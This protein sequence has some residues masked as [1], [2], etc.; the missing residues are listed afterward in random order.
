MTDQP[1][2]ADIR[3]RLLAKVLLT[4]QP[5]VI[6]EIQEID[7]LD[8]LVQ[9]VPE[10]DAEATVI[11]AF[12]VFVKGTARRL[13][14]ATAANN[15][16]AAHWNRAKANR[17]VMP[18]IGLLYSMEGDV[19]YWSWLSEP[20]ASKGSGLPRLRLIDHPD[21]KRIETRTAE[22]LR[23]GIADWY[24]HLAEAVFVTR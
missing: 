21:F 14:D 22:N 15:H 16:L 9:P 24:G 23:S 13:A 3:A 1:K 11:P 6:T 4:R 8:F 17:F 12:G 7:G 2:L 5:S 19:G 10:G 18:V 20:V